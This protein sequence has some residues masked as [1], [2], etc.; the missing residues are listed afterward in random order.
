MFRAHARVS[1]REALGRATD[2]L[3]LVG[4]DRTRVRS[5]PHELSG[6]M[7]QR[8]VIAMALR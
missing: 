3:E 7:R 2:L 1:K 4:I 6:G 8:V 5:Y